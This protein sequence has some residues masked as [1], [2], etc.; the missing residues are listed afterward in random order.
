[1]RNV[2]HFPR[3]ENPVSPVTRISSCRR[4]NHEW[5]K[6]KCEHR[7]NTFGE[8]KNQLSQRGALYKLNFFIHAASGKKI[9]CF[10]SSGCLKTKT[11]NMWPVGGE[12]KMRA[13]LWRNL[14]HLYAEQYAAKIA[15][16]S[17]LQT[18]HKFDDPIS[19]PTL[20]LTTQQLSKLPKLL[21][22]RWRVH[23]FEHG[24][25]IARLHRSTF[26]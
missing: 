4:N 3:E 14:M 18:E 17:R 11:E 21:N 19:T 2:F 16:W 20:L 6:K 1:M 12:I 25:L 5:R 23:N 8:H 26:Y 22:A 24:H 9:T 15:K 10:P 7:K 13:R